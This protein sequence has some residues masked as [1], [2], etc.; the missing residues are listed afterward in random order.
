[1]STNYVVL[2]ETNTPIFRA[3]GNKTGA[4]DLAEPIDAAEE[5][6]AVQFAPRSGSQFVDTRSRFTRSRFG[7][8]AR[9]TK[10]PA[11]SASYPWKFLIGKGAY[12]SVIHVLF[13]WKTATLL[14][15]ASQLFDA[16][17]RVVGATTQFVACIELRKRSGSTSQSEGF[18]ALTQESRLP[19]CLG[20]VPVKLDTPAGKV[21]TY[22]F[23]DTG[24][25]I[26]LVKR[27]LLVKNDVR[28][29]PT[30]IALDTLDVSMGCNPKPMIS[31]F[32]H[33]MK[34]R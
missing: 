5:T 4:Q 29:L 25:G 19:A 13:A 10:F 7:P 20:V 27:D 9:L 11:A 21:I 26:T 33:R 32:Y 24:S 2:F 12:G 8:L 1:Y 3:I 17:S 31:G 15:S 30:S 22:A 14:D 34:I 6:I 16:G 28:M 18:C 23:L